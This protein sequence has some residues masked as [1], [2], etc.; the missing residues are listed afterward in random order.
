MAVTLT[1]EERKHIKGCEA[2]WGYSFK[3]KPL[4]KR[5]L[6]HK[7]Y[8]NEHKLEVDSHNERLEFLGDAVLELCISDLLMNAYPDVQEGELSK[9]R[10]AI[11]NENQLSDIA[12][13]L[14][15]GDFLYLGKGEVQTGGRDKSS[16]LSDALEAMLGAVYMDRGFPAA[17]KVIR[18]LFT[19]LVES[20][21]TTGFIK[22]YKTRLQE[23]SQGRFK[24]IPKY[25]LVSE[26]GPDHQKTFCVDLFIG[27]E[28]YGKGE[29]SN[30]KSAE[31]AAARDALI[32]LEVEGVI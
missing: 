10:A 14:K 30:K 11:V 31:Q 2:L 16:I 15:L 9:I 17:Y 25:R 24:A 4:L 32:K 5:A 27:D 19:T 28:L 7:S 21:Q 18:S 22:D 26:A 20:G 3:S 1:K 23:V 6:T 29:G 8:S 12:R 13:R